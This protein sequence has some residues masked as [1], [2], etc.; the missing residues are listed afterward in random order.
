MW[1]AR[2]ELSQGKRFVNSGQFIGA[3]FHAAQPWRD[4]RGI[5]MMMMIMMMIMMMMVMMIIMMMMVTTT[6]TTTMMIM[7]MMMMMMPSPG[8]TLVALRRRGAHLTAL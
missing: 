8:A 4:S 2:P 1:R 7:M 6:T 5:M 3:P